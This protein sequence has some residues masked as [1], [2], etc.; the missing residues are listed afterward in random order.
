MADGVLMAIFTAIVGFVS[1][2]FGISLVAAGIVT[3]LVIGAAL[4]GLSMLFGPKPPKLTA[5]P[6]PQASATLN[7]SI[8]PRIRGYGRA[9]LGGTRAFWESTNGALY[10]ATMMHSGE[11]D[12]IEEWF[13]GDRQVTLQNGLVAETPWG[14]YAPPTPTVFFDRISEMN[15]DLDYPAGTI[16]G[17][18]GAE[19]VAEELDEFSN[20]I[21]EFQPAEDPSGPYIKIG[22][23]GEGEW[24]DAPDILVSSFVSI[25]SHLGTAGQ[26]ANAALLSA[27]PSIWSAAHQLKG[28]AYFASRYRSPDQEQFQTMFP[29]SFNT[30]VRAVCRLT[31]VFDPRNGN[32]VWSDNPALC[33]LD[34][35][36][37]PDGYRRAIGDID[38]NSFA[39]F[40]NVCDQLV[41]LASGGS[42]KRYRLWG[43]Y[44]LNED[45]QDVLYRMRA[46]CDAEFYQTP[47]GKIA[48]RG[49]KWDIPTVTIEARDIIG[50]RMEQGNNRFSAFNELKILYT[51]PVH[52]Y[53]TME[54]PTWADLTDQAERGVIVDDLALDMVPSPTQ[55]RRLAKIHIAKSNP[56]W[57][58]VIVTN[59]NGLNA[60]GERTIRV[61]IPELQID[62]AFHVAGFSIAPDLTS[63]EISITEIG[64]AAYLW[65]TADEA[66]NAP[67]AQ[68]TRPDISFPVPVIDTIEQVGTAV[69]IVVEDPARD[70]LRLEAQIREGAGGIWVNMFVD[71]GAR[72]ATATSRPAGLNQVRTRWLGVQSTAGAWSEIE[73]IDVLDPP[74]EEPDPE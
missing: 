8:G 3:N 15:A 33:I 69:R 4:T 7:Q 14:Q 36:T 1:A 41:P 19:E 29:E 39:L 58:G 52:D 12:H 62:D 66:T 61:V 27:F 71:G 26:A 60:L 47:E 73:S 45:P 65:T 37:H 34:Y 10:Q 74:P 21:V 22:A 5:Q 50:H 57:R 2:T 31:R 30:P 54:A 38:L 72:V 20:V 46:T 49:G 59:L 56:R 67:I 6:T 11:I 42:E 16:A 53:Q 48:I 51:S 68:D 13:L 63:V 44:Q 17:V 32:T 40:A 64:E 23:T 18:N 35:L 55:A 70:E 9:K 25:S 24:D 43:I 28:I